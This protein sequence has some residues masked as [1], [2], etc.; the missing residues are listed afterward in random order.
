MSSS[1]TKRQV[2]TVSRIHVNRELVDVGSRILKD[3]EGKE[4]V[5]RTKRV[6]AKAKASP[7]F[8]DQQEI[9]AG[10]FV[11]QEAQLSAVG[12]LRA[13]EVVALEET[14]AVTI[15]SSTKKTSRWRVQIAQFILGAL[16]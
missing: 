15:N 7:R 16:L 6:R 10:T 12:P 8:H 11:E 9:G 14:G 1:S 3:V 2:G 13:K 5:E 4:K